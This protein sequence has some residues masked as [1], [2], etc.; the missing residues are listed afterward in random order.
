VGG[1]GAALLATVIYEF[2]GSILFPLATTDR[3]LSAAWESRLAARLLVTLLV[4]AGVV[5]SAESAGESQ[6]VGDAKDLKDGAR[7]SGGA[8][9]SG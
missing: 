1:T 6:G 4:A 8:A 3:P 7:H 5:L 9:T 2:A